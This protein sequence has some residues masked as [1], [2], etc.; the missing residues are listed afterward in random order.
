MEEENLQ[1]QSDMQVPEVEPISKTDALVGVFTEPG[2]TYE[3]IG[4]TKDVYYWLYPILICIVLGLISAFIGQTDKQLFGDMM[5]K[6]KKKMH[7]KMDEQ[8]KAGKLSQEEAQKQIEASEKFMD[9]N[10]FFFKLMAYVGASVGVV[11]IF[12]LVSLLY[13]VGLKIFKSPAGFGDAMNVVGLGLL[14]SSIGGLLA[15]VL[16]VVMGHFV[17]IG[18]G[19]VLKE[20]NVGEKMYKLATTLDVFAIWEHVVFAIGLS[21]VGRISM[22]QSYGLVF[23]LWI[24]W[25]AVSIF[26]F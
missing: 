4:R 17:S 9:P 11:I 25:M 26:V 19:L 23:G 8:V 2:N 22:G 3:A 18:L 13:F 12:I 1:N 5:D 7:E 20:E 21:K 6:Q 15:M 24:I 14:I 16:S 10:G